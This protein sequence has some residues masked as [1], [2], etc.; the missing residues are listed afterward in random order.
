M[1]I[2][3]V[4]CEQWGL[5]T[6][7]QGVE[8]LGKSGFKRWIDAGRVRKVRPRIY[9]AAGAPP[10]WERELL[11][12]CLEAGGVAAARSAARLHGFPYVPSIVPEVVV[13]D[14]RHLHIA[15][16]RLHR[17]NFLPSHHIEIVRR[18]PTVTPPRAMVDISACLGDDTVWRIL[19]EAERLRRF[20]FEEVR[21]CLDEMQARGRRRIAHLRPLLDLCM[22][23]PNGDS[24]PEVRIVRWLLEAGIR[25][26]Q[27][28]L[29][30]VVNGRRYCVD[31]AW[32][33]EKV[34][35]EY[36]GWAVHKMRMRFDGD[37]DKIGELEIG[38]WLIIPVT[39]AMSRQTV[40]DKVRRALALRSTSGR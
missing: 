32:L 37:R 38:G 31:S 12:A 3:D 7:E 26:P 29:W 36:D 11:A 6:W 18:I 25:R 15:G 19:N 23:G 21:Q 24:Q 22:E 28:Q 8:Q 27:Q 39:S 9:V 1:W 5:V 16:A 10:A 20:T 14:G 13:A 2:D 35:L 4:G 40:V 17:T 33:P 34:G 30:V